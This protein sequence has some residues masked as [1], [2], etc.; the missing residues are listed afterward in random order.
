ML[1]HDPKRT[2]VEGVVIAAATPEAAEYVPI[3]AD[4]TAPRI[5]QNG[6]PV[7]PP[8][9]ETAG[10]N[11]PHRVARLDGHEDEIVA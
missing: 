10:P 9:G 5:G 6:M 4:D 3:P 8:G 1:G 11:D 2:D 7:D